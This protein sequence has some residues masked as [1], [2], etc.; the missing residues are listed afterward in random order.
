MERRA[1]SMLLLSLALGFLQT[2]TVACVCVQVLAPCTVC[3][4]WQ[5]LNNAG[6]VK[7]AG[8]RHSGLTQHSSLYSPG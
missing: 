2:N 8:H 1:C 3:G 5:A 6:G 7:G 4:T